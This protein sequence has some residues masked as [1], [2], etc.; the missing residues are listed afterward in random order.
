VHRQP[1]Q[2]DLFVDQLGKRSIDPVKS[3]Q[4]G[5]V[6]SEPLQDPGNAIGLLST[7]LVDICGS[8]F[9]IVYG[10]VSRSA[11]EVG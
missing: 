5:E 3:L 7:T 1:E 4:A 9:A 10:I 11:V 2:P 8:F 6:G